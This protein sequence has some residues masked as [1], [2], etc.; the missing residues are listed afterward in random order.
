MVMK[1]LGARGGL[2]VDFRYVLDD[3]GMGTKIVQLL[4]GLEVPG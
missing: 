4:Q 1:F 3:L 2:R